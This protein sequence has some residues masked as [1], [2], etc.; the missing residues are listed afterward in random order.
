MREDSLSPVVDKTTLCL[1]FTMAARKKL[2]MMQ[3]DVV[4]A[5]LNANMPDE[6]FV[7]LPTLVRR[8]QKALYGHPSAGKL[9]NTDFV[10][11]TSDEGFSP[12]S[13]DRCLFFHPNLIS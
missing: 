9:W 2:F 11:F 10:V 13:R 12:T 4:M 1:L 5:Y 8:L 3:A 6:V 7:K